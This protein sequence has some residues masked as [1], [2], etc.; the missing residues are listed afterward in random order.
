MPAAKSG[1]AT[2][3]DLPVRLIHWSLVVLIPFAWWTYKTD[4]MLWHARAGYAVLALLS[5]RLFWGVFGSGTA[6]FANFVRG[7]GAVMR[8]LRGAP[9]AP[10][11]NPLGGWSVMALLAVLVVQPLAGL[12][13][14]DEN[15]LES[16]PLSSWISLDQA[17]RAEDIHGLLFNVLLGL[18]AL[19]IAAILLYALRGRN[20]T[21]PM[22]TGR[23]VLPP[24]VAAPK[25]ASVIALIAGVG[26]AAAA[27]FVLW[28][29]GS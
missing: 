5:F 9:Q 10:G 6:R 26:L 2:I 8:Y 16:G 24:G 4:R 15:G 22:I 7:P 29:L 28:R 25:P 17:Q 14:S 21:G 13:V 18:V 11:H 1:R 23:A 20:L 27:F 19:H 3:W 12:F